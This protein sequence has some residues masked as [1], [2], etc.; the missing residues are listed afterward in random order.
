MELRF[1][2]KPDGGLER[3][4][5]VANRIYSPTDS[6][7]AK[8]EGNT[9]RVVLHYPDMVDLNALRERIETA[10]TPDP[11]GLEFS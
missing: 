11:D 10:I 3:G 1:E 6:I 2:L 4:H 9:L 5:E 7:H 8:V